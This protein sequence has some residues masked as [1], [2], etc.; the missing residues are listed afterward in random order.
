METK[1]NYQGKRHWHFNFWRC[2]GY[3]LLGILG[4]GAFL[5]LGGIVIMLL[6]NG[7]MPTLFQFTTIS[8]WQA[9]GL[10]LLARLLFGATH[11]GMHHFG[12]RGWRH[13]HH[14]CCGDN[15]FQHS[16]NRENFQNECQCNS[17][18]WQYYDKFWE[19]EGEKAFHDYVKRKNEGSDKSQETKI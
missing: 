9:V 17:S 10:A 14:S 5:L 2:T 6:W 13:P 16:H 15:S 18:T 19:E 1:E 7:L 3:G 4:F 8:F 11:H 12:R